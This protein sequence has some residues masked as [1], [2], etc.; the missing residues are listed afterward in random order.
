MTTYFLR[1]RSILGRFLKRSAKPGSATV[2]AGSHTRSPAHSGQ[3]FALPRILWIER[4]NL[5]FD[6][7][8][9]G[10]GSLRA[11]SATALRRLGQ[12]RDIALPSQCAL[13]GNLSQK[14]LCAG[15]DEQYWNQTRTR[16]P[17]CALPVPVLAAASAASAGAKSS[18]HLPCRRCMAE[19]PHFDATI[20]LA[21]YHAPL[22]TLALDLKFHAR[23]STADEFARQ[24]HAAFE[25]TN[26]EAPDVVAPVPLSPR[27]LRTRGYNQA[28]SIGK[29]LARRLGSFA[30]ATLIERTRDTAPQAKLDL[31]T[32][33]KN[34]GNAFTVLREIRGQHVGIVDDVMTS[35][36]TLDALAFTLKAAGARRVT[37]FVALRT[38]QD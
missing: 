14:V 6:V 24:L 32:R 33:R 8:W 12:M 11:A 3:I 17:V 29:P 30:D 25:G 36:A 4:M 21:D 31:D 19:P 22:D 18:A 10:P 16:C 26:T 28:W 27:R 1:V 23:L 13:C 7:V 38:P 9:R 5:R 34:V 37:N 15:C 35:G 20:A 2:S